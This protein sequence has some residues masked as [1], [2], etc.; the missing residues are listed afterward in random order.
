MDGWA[1]IHFAAAAGHAPTVAALVRAGADTAAP[2][3]DGETA[4]SLAEQGRY[5]EVLR[6]LEG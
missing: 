2:T 1:A 6:A 5:A 4:K 3:R